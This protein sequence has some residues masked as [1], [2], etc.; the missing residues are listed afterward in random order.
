MKVCLQ[1]PSK[2][3]DQAFIRGLMI[4]YKSSFLYTAL[5]VASEKVAGFTADIL[6]GLGRGGAWASASLSNFARERDFNLDKVKQDNPAVIWLGT[7]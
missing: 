1:K 4:Y 6:E 7:L 5:V 3:R 2:A